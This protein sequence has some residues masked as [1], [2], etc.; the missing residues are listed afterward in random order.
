MKNHEPRNR[1][2]KGKLP[3]DED[4]VLGK[5]TRRLT[6]PRPGR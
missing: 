3:L 4:G 2:L 1:M 6:D 5:I